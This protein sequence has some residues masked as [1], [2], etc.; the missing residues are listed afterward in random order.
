[1]FQNNCEDFALYCKT[2]LLILD[3]LRIGRSGQVSSMVGVPLA[4]L[5]SSSR[6]LMPTSIGVATVTAGMYCI[7]M[8]M[9][10]RPASRDRRDRSRCLLDVLKEGC[11]IALRV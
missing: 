7:S 11:G 9:V 3:T 10:S 4:A 2:G 1:M 5:I 6:G 8:S